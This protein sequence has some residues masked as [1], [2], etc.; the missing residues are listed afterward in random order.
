VPASPEPSPTPA[1]PR[2][3]QVVGTGLIGGSVG[4]ALRASGWRVTGTD[5]D[6]GVAER[7][8]HLGAIDEVGIDGDAQLTVLAAPVGRIAELAVEFLDRTAGA[9][10]DVGS[11]K[12]AVARAIDAPRF[13]GGH[14]MAGSEQDGIEG[15]RGDLFEGATWVLTPT[16]KTDEHA[17]A[18]VSAAVRGM[19]AE[20]LALEP[21]VHDE[22]VALVSHVP[23]LTAAA[24]MCLAD[25]SSIEHRALL[26]LAAGG[27]RDMTRISA[28]RPAIWPDICVANQPAITAGLDRLIAELDRIRA[29][30]ADQDRP[31]LLDLLTRAR[32]ARINLPSGY[33]AAEALAEV[34]IPIPDRPG[35]IAAITTLASELDVNLIDLEITHSSEGRRGVLVVVVDAGIAERL[36]GGLMAK[37]YRPSLRPLE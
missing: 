6:A 3:A 31:G 32:H 9:V 20:V 25:E 28:G 11:T 4:M 24:L 22:L 29:R 15:A 30:V 8:R 23:H 34:A 13:V 33:A 16:E 12:A 14:P 26:R 2:R 27:F 36:V 19:G 35:E 1:G 18:T 17:F 10:T 37:G 5:A 21:E 7:A